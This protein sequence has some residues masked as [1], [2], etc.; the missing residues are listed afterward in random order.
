MVIRFLVALTAIAACVMF[1]PLAM[2]GLVSWIEF[3]ARSET[4]GST[5]LFLLGVA[6]IPGGIAGA[7]VC[8]AMIDSVARDQ[9]GS[10]ER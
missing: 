5:K 10:D 6:S 9:R 4:E 3:L 1:F 2:F 7:F 8:T